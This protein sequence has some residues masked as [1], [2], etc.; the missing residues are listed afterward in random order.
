MPK[1]IQ[2]AHVFPGSL[3]GTW[4]E[5]VSVAIM[6]VSQQLGGGSRRIPI[7]RKMTSA[8]HWPSAWNKLKAN[9]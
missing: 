7:L 2:C 8:A 1:N 9:F 4:I 5:N 3:A 6:P